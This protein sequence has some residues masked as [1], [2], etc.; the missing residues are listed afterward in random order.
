[1]TALGLLLAVA[2]ATCAN[3]RASCGLSLQTPSGRNTKSAP[4][5][6]RRVARGIAPLKRKHFVQEL[7][8]YG[9]VVLA[10]ELKAAAYVSYDSSAAAN[11]RYRKHSH[12]QTYGLRCP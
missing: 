11:D 5:H 4:L 12:C 8:H 7:S 9:Q 3:R 10:I 1:M 2:L 6:G